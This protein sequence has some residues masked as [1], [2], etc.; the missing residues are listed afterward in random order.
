[1]LAA[2][3]E[4]GNKARLVRAIQLEAVLQR[5]GCSRDGPDKAKWHT[6][7]GVISV[8]G[9]KFMNWSQGTGGGG[10]ID[11]AMHL[12]RCDFKTA[13]FWLSHGFSATGIQ[14]LQRATSISQPALALPKRDESRVQQVR[15]YLGTGRCIPRGLIDFLIRSGKLYADNRANAVFLL[16]GKEKK[17]VGAE[18]RGTRHSRWHGLAPG[19]RKDLG[20]FY[21]KSTNTRQA[22]LCESAIDAIS[23]FALHPNCLAL[24]TSGANPSP[25]WLSILI[26][27]GFDV[28]CGFD[29][30]ETG[31]SLADRMIRRYPTVKRLRPPEKD[32]NEVLQSRTPLH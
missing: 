17:V 11:L 29:S 16:L 7:E 13:V 8:T 12:R 6:P 2:F 1:M 20:C 31:D 25:A 19:S 5:T 23:Y 28:Y 21:V 9:Q 4:I 18:L 14:T 32:W 15:D 26:G 24:S 30:D 10:A 22:V 3:E 27:K